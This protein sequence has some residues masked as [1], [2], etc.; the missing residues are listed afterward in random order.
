VQLVQ[1]EHVYVTPLLTS[2]EM[3]SHVPPA[4]YVVHSEYVSP[5]D[6]H[7]TDDPHDVV[8]VPCELQ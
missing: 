6:P 3:D 7:V 5:L 4:E 1:P 2:Y 8:G